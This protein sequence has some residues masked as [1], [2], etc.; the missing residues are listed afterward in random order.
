MSGLG[1]VWWV[2]EAGSPRSGLPL[3]GPPIPAH[4]LPSLYPFLEYKR[5]QVGRKGLLGVAQDRCRRRA[6][7]KWTLGSGPATHSLPVPSR[8]SFRPKPV[9]DMSHLFSE[10]SFLRR[11]TDLPHPPCQGQFWEF[12][13]DLMPTQILKDRLVSQGHLLYISWMFSKFNHGE[14]HL[15]DFLVSNIWIL[16]PLNDVYY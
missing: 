9:T 16:T 2:S 12:S 14:I 3:I 11:S 10:T 6:R 4:T 15:K 7:V 13:E 1:W 8:T 5:C